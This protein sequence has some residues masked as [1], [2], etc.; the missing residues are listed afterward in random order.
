MLVRHPHPKGGVDTH[1][2]NTS[3]ADA[4]LLQFRDDLFG[5][6][7]GSPA[8]ILDYRNGARIGYVVDK[9]RQQ[10]WLTFQWKDQVNVALSTLEPMKLVKMSDVQ[11]VVQEFNQ[12]TQ[13]PQIPQGPIRQNPP[14]TTIA[15]TSAPQQPQYDQQQDIQPPTI[16]QTSPL[17]Q[18][19]SEKTILPTQ[20]LSAKDT[21]TAVMELRKLMI[22]NLK[23]FK[24]QYSE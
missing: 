5:R 13:S 3:F 19:I 22:E 18:P 24:R 2:P 12:S 15:F 8:C 14:P 6:L 11:R 21:A 1:Q 4:R 23:K 20:P 10:G 16:G 9:T 7:I 17:P